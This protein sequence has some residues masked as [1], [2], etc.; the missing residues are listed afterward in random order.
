MQKVNPKPMSNT[1]TLTAALTL[2]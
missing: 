1:L 2:T